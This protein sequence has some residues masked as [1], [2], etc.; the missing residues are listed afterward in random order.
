MGIERTL[1]LIKPDAL[2]KGLEFEVLDRIQNKGFTFPL[3]YKTNVGLEVLSEHYANV[4]ERHGQ[5]KG[6]WAVKSMMDGPLIAAMVE[7]E[8]AAAAVREIAGNHFDPTKCNPG[9]IRSDFSS[10]SLAVADSQE[11]GIHNIIH[12]SDSE[13][14]AKREIY[15]WFKKYLP[16]YMQKKDM[17]YSSIAEAIGHSYPDLIRSIA[18]VSNQKRMLYHGIKNPEIAAKVLTEGIKPMSPELGGCSFWATGNN[19]FFPTDDSVLFNHSGQYNRGGS[20]EC[21][22]AMTNYSSLCAGQNPL[23]F[24]A[25]S[26]IVMHEVLKPES[27]ALLKVKIAHI[28]D[29]EP[30]K[31]RKERQAAENVMLRA[32]DSQ[33]F[34]KFTP[35]TAVTYEKEGQWLISKT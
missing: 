17:R 23:K 26:Q 25:N 4:F 30:A 8:N 16:S 28:R 15:L 33:L 29:Y 11:R 6:L 3:M 5:T 21:T 22:I 31:L 9:T 32:I 1:I 18:E 7:G 24:E 27:F 2:K 10:D 14:T 12:T 20:I 34:E 35:G 13:K 19:L